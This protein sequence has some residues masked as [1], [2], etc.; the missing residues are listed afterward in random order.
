[1]TYLVTGGTGFIG[2]EIT[3]LLVHDGGKVVIYQRNPARSQVEELLEKETDKKVVI[4]RGDISDLAHLVRTVQKYE[5]ERIIHLSSLHAPESAANPL[6]ALHINCIGTTHIFET[7]RILGV[8]KVVWASSGR[9]F[10]PPERYDQ[11]YITDDAPHYPLGVYG[12]CKSFNEDMAKHYFDGYGVDIIGLRFGLVYGAARSE[13]LGATLI[14]ELVLKPAVGKEGRVPQG[15]S[16]ANWLYV[17]DAARAAVMASR[18]GKTKTRSFNLNGDIRSMSEAVDCVK[19]IIPDAKLTLSPGSSG[20]VVKYNAT[21]AK[22]E[23]GYESRWTLE[24]G[25]EKMI[26]DIRDKTARGRSV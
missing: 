19:K 2:A 3:R 18:A 15:D 12:A 5:V 7:A 14:E 4:I 1:M 25:I 16:I 13:G 9:V 24:K 8:K 11:E 6:L 22:E 26:R 23:I 17:E 21:R 10:G 20:F